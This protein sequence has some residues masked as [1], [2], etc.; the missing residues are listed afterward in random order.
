[1]KAHTRSQWRHEEAGD[2]HLSWR[3]VAL[4]AV[5][6]G[7]TFAVF[8]QERE[9]SPSRTMIVGET[10][11]SV[12][13]PSE[14]R[15]VELPVNRRVTAA[16][17]VVS[18][19]RAVAWLKEE[20][21]Y[22][23]LA[24]AVRAARYAMER[25]N[26]TLPSSRGAEFFAENPV[27]QLRGWFGRDGVEFASG[28]NEDWSFA[29]RMTGAS[30][31]VTARQ[32]RAEVQRAGVV[33]W[34][35]N[36]DAGVEQGF[37]IGTPPAQH[38]ELR[39]AMKMSGDLHA[40]VESEDAIVFRTAAGQPVLRYA[41]LHATDALGRALPVRMELTDSQLALV[42]DDRDAVY[43][44]M[45]DPLITTPP[46]AKLVADGS[47]PESAFAD[48]VALDGDSAVFGAYG[49][50]TPVAAGAG[51]AYVFTRTGTVWNQ[52][53]KLYA[54]DGAAGDSF[55]D[56]VA[57]SGDTVIV[58]SPG[59]DVPGGY[60]QAGAAYV[61]VRSGGAWSE[62]QK[63]N[64]SVTNWADSLGVAVAIEGDTA[65]VGAK[66]TDIPGATN[67]GA[68]YVFTR[69][70]AVWA[71]AALLMASDGAT[72]DSF[73]Q[74]VALTTTTN[75]ADTVLVGSPYAS[76]GAAYTG[77]AY[78][79]THEAGTWTQQAKLVAS[80]AAAH[81]IFGF[82]VALSGPTALVGAYHDDTIHGT[83]AGSAYVFTRAG[84]AWTEQANLLPST[85]G[86]A[87]S[88]GFS[89]ALSGDTALVGSR[90]ASVGGVTGSGAAH[91]FVRTGTTWSQQQALD[92]GDAQL[93]GVF[94]C[95]VALSGDRALVG[96]TL[97]DSSAGP[98]SGSGYIF[99]RTGTVWTAQAKL[100]IAGGAP[101]DLFGSAVALQENTA[102]VGVPN[103]DTAAG[104]NAGCAYV[105]T[106]GGN[107]WTPRKKLTASDGAAE[108][109]FGA[110]VAITTYKAVIGAPGADPGGVADAG[111]AYVFLHS[112]MTWIFEEKL[113]ASDGAAQDHFGQSVAI[114]EDKLMVGAP[115]VDGVG[116]ADYGA[117]YAYQWNGLNWS[118]EQKLA[119]DTLNESSQFG[120]AVAMS[121]DFAVVGAPGTD[122]DGVDVGRAYAFVWNTP[123]A[124][125]W[126]PHS[127]LSAFTSVGGYLGYSVA[128]DGDT[129]VLGAPSATIVG[130]HGQGKAAVFVRSGDMW[131]GPV[132]LT[133]TD[134]DTDDNFGA[135]VAVDG[136][137]VAIGAWQMDTP[138]W[139][140]AGAV[141]LYSRAGTAWD[142]STR[143]L[144]P[145]ASHNDRLG[146]S[147]A[148][149]GDTILAGTMSGNTVN[150]TDAGSAYAFVLPLPPS[151][152]VISP[153]TIGSTNANPLYAR[154]ADT[155]ALTFTADKPLQTPVVT[156]A[157][158]DVVPVNTSGNTWR[159]TLPVVDADP[160]G[161]VAF[162]LTATALDGT[163]T[164]PITATTGGG[165]VT[166]DT[167]L[168]TITGGTSPRIIFVGTP[169]ANYL[170]SAE[171]TDVTPLTTTQTPPA[172]TVLAQ[173][174]SDVVLSA[175]DAAGN[176]QV[177]TFT[178][179]VRP[180]NPMNTLLLA[181][182]D[183]APGAGT[184]GG[185]PANA[186]L[187]TFG[188]PAVD[189]L[190][191]VAFTAKW[192][193][194]PR[195]GGSGIF[196]KTA[197]IATVGGAVP[198]VSNATFRTLSDPVIES[199]RIAFLATLGGVPKT[200]ASA[201]MSDAPSGS[202]AVIARTGEAAPGAGGGTFKAFKAISVQDDSVAIFAQLKAAAASDLGLWLQDATH[203]L[204][205]VLREGQ[206]VNNRTIK[207]LVAFAVGSGSPGA[208]RGWHVIGGGQPHVLALA[209]F[210]DRTQAVLGATR[211]GAVTVFSQS[212]AGGAGGPTIAN[213]TF[214]SYGLPAV[215]SS[216]R[217]AFLGTLTTGAGGVTK[218]NAR[219]VFANVSGTLFTPILRVGDVVSSGG[220]AVTALK[221]PVF[222]LDN[223]LAFA[224]TLKGGGFK[225]DATK[226]IF[227][228]KS[229]GSLDLLAQG[230]AG[231]R[232]VPDLPDAQFKTFTS[233]AVAPNRGPLFTATL[234]PGK[235]G[236]TKTSASGLW[237]MDFT[238]D[239]R[240]IFRLGD[241]V[242][243][244][245]VKTFTLLNA[246]RGSTG[247]TRSFNSIGHVAWLATFKEDKSQAIVV[248][249]VP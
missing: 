189:D 168:P 222:S 159:A 190:G 64:V 30:G 212:G 144:H 118:D 167:I 104:S 164:G 62:Q 151:P 3:W 81:D 185:P 177:K 140:D 216:G 99:N 75:P 76:A 169:L 26:P 60:T 243:G 101:A 161:A 171:I 235:G 32:D 9:A 69:S 240:L 120:S 23:S 170:A 135:S 131:N 200:S 116:G 87:F 184:T 95:A 8:W 154:T 56:A 236:V 20:G 18:G 114:D 100:T 181:K 85:G 233:L 2:A 183:L 224:A 147:V 173:G 145:D 7:I 205:L 163:T 179:A 242:G 162:S 201:V 34:Y 16:P 71:Q 39:V 89:V 65:I 234:V 77:A 61:F 132:M 83:A 43:P 21:S 38:G 137:R 136:D 193:A 245:T 112:G 31:T 122:A 37:I 119:H 192:T 45:I 155:I 194:A 230:G 25:L 232:V 130:R 74:A 213:A 148:I 15:A 29:L 54:S 36:T 160:Q 196:T 51:A 93:Y 70:G 139:L 128:L 79:F 78:V 156:I 52:E 127:V 63:L 157:G 238:G 48:A 239:L 98:R 150:G 66:G 206:V 217:G 226:T 105:F 133:A 182:G 58:G 203:P 208:G 103:G 22:E 221:D 107:V 218:A 124:G 241:S 53:A 143:L 149:S 115:G 219:G 153:V 33:E 28:R 68:A 111:S 123:V 113:S 174:W 117:A 46:Q 229:T 166:I 49:A 195:G 134:G 4:A 158:H 248:S 198:G 41:D 125:D 19:E 204:A 142:L 191:N 27:Q 92:P 152:P 86:S 14:H 178:L 5:L 247:V 91:V 197:C 244:K 129:A 121:G 186:L 180:V 59:S 47:M 96:S 11:W 40:T 187:A 215:S 225:G 165:G 175:T 138:A 12:A 84:T 13:V 6:A 50:N 106:R 108:D 172:G 188:V 10:A 210:T 109:H 214:A 24:D 141:Y 220:A 42:V 102:L 207:T 73:G 202:L 209:L 249:D 97:S 35:E 90:D 110:S 237:A 72:G 211:D 55:G 57:V 199:G 246:T 228:R 94:G 176:E 17:A 227:W 146:A 88:F 223:T 82:S 67:A 44:L 80:D 126:S 1:M 231:N